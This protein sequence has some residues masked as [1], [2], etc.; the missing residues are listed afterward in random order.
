MVGCR[1]VC[2]DKEGA[3]R[4]VDSAKHAFGFSV[5]SGGVRA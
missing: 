5:L 4:V 2:L 1:H 3:N